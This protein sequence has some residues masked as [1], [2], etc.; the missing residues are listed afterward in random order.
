MPNI[1]SA[2]RRMRVEAKAKLRNRMIKSELKTISK[3]FKAAV[4]AGD[5]EAALVLFKEYTSA[6]D[7]A[8]LKG[9]LHPNN[10][11]RK[12][13]QISKMVSSITA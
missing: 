7:K 10:A 6:L 11:N 1:K 3:K 8:A 2:E 12:K 9:T 5:K 13:A 4:D